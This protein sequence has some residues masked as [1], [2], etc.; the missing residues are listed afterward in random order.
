MPFLKKEL[1]CVAAC[2]ILFSHDY[3]VSTLQQC[4]ALCHCNSVLHCVTATVCCTVSLQQYPCRYS[5]VM[6]KEKCC[7][8]LHCVTACWI[9]ALSA[10]PSATETDRQ[11]PKYQVFSVVHISTVDMCNSL[12]Q[13]VAVCHC[14]SVL[15]CVTATVCCTVSLQQCVAVCYCNSMLQCVTATVCCSVS[16]QQYPHF[17]SF[18]M[19]Y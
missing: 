1:Q 8:V 13:C 9:R 17:S 2:W 12:Q 6:T 3:R 11:K 4:V 5:S 18:H 19:C 15:H 10:S 14:N 16:L 7:G